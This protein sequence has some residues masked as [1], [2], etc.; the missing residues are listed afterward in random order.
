MSDNIL[1]TAHGRDELSNNFGS[2]PNILNTNT[3]QNCLK[4]CFH[5]RHPKKTFQTHVFEG[6]LFFFKNGVFARDI[7]PKWLSNS[8]FFKTRKLFESRFARDILQKSTVLR[9]ENK[10]KTEKKTKTDKLVW[11]EKCAKNIVIYDTQM[12]SSIT[13]WRDALPDGI[14]RGAP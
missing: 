6:A 3:C 13:I 9:T 4:L 1:C 14:R 7:P 10:T 11:G 2:Y 5:S 12:T 8:Q